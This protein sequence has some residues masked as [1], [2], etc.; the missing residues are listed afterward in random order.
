[1]KKILSLLLA[2]MMVVS[3]CPVTALA[4]DMNPM[5]LSQSTELEEQPEQPAEEPQ[6]EQPAEEQQSEMNSLDLNGGE[7][8]P[9]AEGE[10]GGYYTENGAVIAFDANGISGCNYTVDGAEHTLYIQNTGINRNV[11]VPKTYIVRMRAADFSIKNNGSA[12]VNLQNANGKQPVAVLEAGEQKAAADLPNIQQVKLA[13]LTSAGYSITNA[14]EVYYMYIDSVGDE[15][16][17]AAILIEIIP[18]SIKVDGS[19]FAAEK[20]ELTGWNRVKS[21]GS[22]EKVE[23]SNIYMITLP[24]GDENISLDLNE[25][26]KYAGQALGSEKTEFSNVSFTELLANSDYAVTGD[27][28]AE[29]VSCTALF[30]ESLPGTL[31]DRD[32]V[33]FIAAYDK[34]GNTKA[35]I[36]VR[37]YVPDLTVTEIA[38][39]EDLVA[40]REYVNAGNT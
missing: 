15:N 31:S 4:S 34:D 17:N 30:G 32:K 26:V 21:D 10:T 28:K 2:V 3:L 40:F 24:Y 9:L 19:E 25:A 13:T 38:T 29:G 20:T 12:S 7:A 5:D 33:V 22:T 11:T 1:M 14:A 16:L 18:D 39:A 37:V 35:G 23:C 8:A 6:E 27:K 36:I